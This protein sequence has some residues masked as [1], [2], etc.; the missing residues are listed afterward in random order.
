MSIKFICSCGKHLL[1]RDE[2]AG[3]RSVC[4]QCGMPVGIPFLNPTHPGAALGHMTPAERLRHRR[5]ARTANEVLQEMGAA[6]APAQSSA[7]QAG[8]ATGAPPTSLSQELFPKPLD[9]TLVRLV[10]SKQRR[11]WQLETRWYQCLLYPLRAWWLI[12]PAGLFLALSFAGVLFSLPELLQLRANPLGGALVALPGMLV[13]LL[14]L[15]YTASLPEG[16]LI[17][18]LA[19]EF[20]HIHWPGRSITLAVRSCVVWLLCFVAGPIFLVAASIVYWIYCGDPGFLDAFILMEL[21]LGAI[22]YAYLALLSFCRRERLWDIN[23]WYVLLLLDRLELRVLCTLCLTA[24]LTLVEGILAILAMSRLQRHAPAGWTL[25][26]VSCMS[27][28]FVVTFLLRL[29]GVWC[30]RARI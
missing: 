23:P 2:M 28:L 7:P 8:H 10:G 25:L 15:G 27:G 21:N 5:Q 18:G 19:G 4:P 13:L 24:V 26:I 20:R 9:P 22:F 1:A 17:S 30:Y 14:V 3:R 6:P 16:A 12:A 11:D 29:I